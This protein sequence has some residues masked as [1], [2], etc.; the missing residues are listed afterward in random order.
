MTEQ[1]SL[2]AASRWLL[3]SPG[4]GWTRIEYGEYEYERAPSGR[5]DFSPTGVIERYA[6][7]RKPG[8][9]ETITRAFRDALSTSTG[10]QIRVLCAFS[11]NRKSELEFAL[12]RRSDDHRTMVEYR[13]EPGVLLW[14]RTLDGSQW[15]RLDLAGDRDAA[16]MLPLMR[17][18]LGPTIREVCARRSGRAD[19][20]VPELN[21][22]WAPTV[23]TP[24]VT[25][26]S[27]RLISDEALSIALAERTWSCEAYQFLGG[28]YDSNSTFWICEDSQRLIRYIFEAQSGE[29]W[30]A[31]LV[32]LDS[33]QT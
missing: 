21:D 5:S 22:P 13:L 6:V 26:R 28:P 17:N 12:Y 31:E 30:S 20:I 23:F 8:S 2:L 7:W 25:P 16:L 29:R 14:R 27:A 24:T 1:A 33:S 18:F 3:E 9:A 19:V 15:E 10:V 11:P 4:S 32:R